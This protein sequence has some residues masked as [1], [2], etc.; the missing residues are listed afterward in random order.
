MF[1][2]Y[3]MDHNNILA[4]TLAGGKS[5]NLEEINLKSN[6]QYS[7][8]LYFRRNND[9]YKDILVWQM[10]QLNFRTQIKFL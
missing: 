9:F 7:Y 10:N 6:G 5:K 3:L 4:V 2:F 1:I 8:R